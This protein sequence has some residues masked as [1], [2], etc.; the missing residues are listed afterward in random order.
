MGSAI[1]QVACGRRHLI[2]AT[3]SGRLQACGLAGCGQL[4][5]LSSP[6]PTLVSL[7]RIVSMPWHQPIQVA[8]QY[9]LLHPNFHKC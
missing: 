4:G 2:V 6:A 5:S 3:A 7:P 8:I 1:V 9:K